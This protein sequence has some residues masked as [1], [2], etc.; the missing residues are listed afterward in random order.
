[1]NR[2]TQLSAI[3]LC[4]AFL[5]AAWAHQ[6]PG[7]GGGARDG[8]GQAVGKKRAS[9]ITVLDFGAKGD[10]KTDDAASIQDLIDAKTGTIRFPAGT[11][12][13]TQPLVIDLDKVG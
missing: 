6:Q 7:T 5:I 4:G 8:L 12:R 1:M 11:Y 2:T 9:F 10:G 3:F 13:L